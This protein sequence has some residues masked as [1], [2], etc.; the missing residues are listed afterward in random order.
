[1]TGYCFKKAQDQKQRKKKNK[2]EGK[3]GVWAIEVT[4]IVVWGRIKK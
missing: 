3:L 1:M 2:R 4:I